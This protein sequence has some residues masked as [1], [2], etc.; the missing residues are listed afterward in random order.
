M[1]DV[2]DRSTTGG[3]QADLRRIPHP[4]LSELQIQDLAMAVFS[5]KRR[6]SVRHPS[7]PKG[8][9]RRHWDLT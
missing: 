9:I 7:E 1:Q 3:M 8:G 5:Q 4:V 6:F 2:P